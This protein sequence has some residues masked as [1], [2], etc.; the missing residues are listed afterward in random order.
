MV[1]VVEE[2][3]DPLNFAAVSFLSSTTPSNNPKS[4]TAKK[5][6]RMENRPPR[7]NT[8]H[9]GLN[10]YFTQTFMPELTLFREFEPSSV[11]L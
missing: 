4:D 10:S 2:A 7:I 5:K 6:R 11:I 8:E 9:Q 3:V 1:V